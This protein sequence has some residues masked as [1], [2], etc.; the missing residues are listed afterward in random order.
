MSIRDL[1]LLLAILVIFVIITDTNITSHRIDKKLDK[2]SYA[3]GI[4]VPKSINMEAK[5]FAQDMKKQGLV[6][7][8]KPNPNVSYGWEKARMLTRRQHEPAPASNLLDMLKKHEGKVLDKR[9]LHAPYRDTEGYL[10]IGYGCNIDG[11]CMSAAGFKWDGKPLNEA[12]ATRLL[13]FHAKQ[14]KNQLKASNLGGFNQLNQARKDALTDMCYNMGIK[15]LSTF[16]NTLRFIK[17]AD[18]KRAAKNIKSS[19]Y[20]KQTKSRCRT[21]SRIIKTGKYPS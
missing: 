18:Y 20:C 15:G 2:I 7:T 17:K 4:P 6:W 13:H 9:G 16:K 12:Q 5:G 1:L 19:L 14:C 11:G 21:I 3:M 10:T 8:V